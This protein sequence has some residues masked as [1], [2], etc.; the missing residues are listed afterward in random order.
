MAEQGTVL[1][2]PLPMSLASRLECIQCGAVAEAACGCGCEYVPAWKRA[3][4]AVVANPDKSDRMIA[5]ETGISRMTINR[6]RAATVP[7]VTVDKRVGRD[8]KKR[9]K[10]QKNVNGFRIPIPNGYASLSDAITS[11]IEFE[12]Q[13]NSVKTS[14][15]FGFARL[16]YPP[17][18]DIVL[19][20]AR[21]DLSPKQMGIAKRAQDLLN[22]EQ[23]YR[24]A[25]ALVRPIASK[26]WGRNGNRFKTEVKRIEAFLSSVGIVVTACTVAAEIPV[27][28]LSEPQRVAALAELAEAKTAFSLLIRRIK[29]S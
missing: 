10:A 7:D 20:A 19:L 26:I 16:S 1:K 12:R 21:T 14:Q 28:H 25:Y 27:P 13:S 15:K 8:G 17:M 24:K 5:Q 29:G 9:R 23:Q 22:E 2:F 11:A 4:E 3:A 6:A 18:R